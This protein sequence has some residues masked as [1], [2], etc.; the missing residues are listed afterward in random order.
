MKDNQGS[1][2]AVIEKVKALFNS[3]KQAWTFMANFMC[4]CPNNSATGW[5]CCSEQSNCATDPCPCPDGYHVSASVACCTSVCGGLAGSGLMTPFSYIEG[6]Q[7]AESL[8]SSMG[9]YL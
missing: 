7:L 3:T 1:K 9:K 2:D 8:L 4:T 6:D 5:E